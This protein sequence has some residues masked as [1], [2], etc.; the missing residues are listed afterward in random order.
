M[1]HYVQYPG[2]LRPIPSPIK[3]DEQR[4]A[5]ACIDL[6]H[7]QPHKR[8]FVPEKELRTDQTEFGVQTLYGSRYQPRWPSRAMMRALREEVV[9]ALIRAAVHDIVHGVPG[10]PQPPIYGE[11]PIETL[12]PGLL[13]RTLPQDSDHGRERRRGERRVGDRRVATQER[14]QMRMPLWSIEKC[15]RRK[16]PWERR[17]LNKVGSRDRRFRERRGCQSVSNRELHCPWK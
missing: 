14:R 1:T 5:A 3:G 9:P 8:R 12:C 11:S 6:F 4:R 7:R 13:P 2:G 15:E 10:E 17:W 16:L